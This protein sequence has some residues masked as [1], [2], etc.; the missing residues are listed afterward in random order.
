MNTRANTRPGDG[1]KLADEIGWLI[2]HE[3]E[4]K[5]LTL[6]PGEAAYEVCWSKE[7]TAALRFARRVDAEDYAATFLDEGPVRITE[8]MW[9]A[10]RSQP[11]PSDPRSEAIQELIRRS[12][13]ARGDSADEPSSWPTPSEDAPE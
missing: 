5:W 3:D 8:H 10:L 7:S 4:P 6:K 2:E 12:R 11:T 9:P 13:L 1:G